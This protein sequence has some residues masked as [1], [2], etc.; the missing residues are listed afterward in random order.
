MK[1]AQNNIDGGCERRESYE[2]MKK[3]DKKTKETYLEPDTKSLK[4]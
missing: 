4:L 1:D 3:Q 2:T